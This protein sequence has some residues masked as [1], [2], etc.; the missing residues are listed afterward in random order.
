[1]PSK[2]LRSWKRKIHEETD[3]ILVNAFYPAVREYTV[4]SVN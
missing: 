1:M 2:Q 3:L 4:Q